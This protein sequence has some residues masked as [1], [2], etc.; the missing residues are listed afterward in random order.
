[1]EIT[2]TKGRYK[3]QY[4]AENCTSSWIIPKEN[5]FQKTFHIHSSIVKSTTSQVIYNFPQA[6]TTADCGIFRFLGACRGG[7]GKVLVSGKK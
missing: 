1:M 3:R 6:F 5:F 4:P 7:Y 2:K